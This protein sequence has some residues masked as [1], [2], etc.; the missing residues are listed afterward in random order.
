MLKQLESGRKAVLVSRLPRAAP[1]A[2]VAR[3]DRSPLSARCPMCRVADHVRQL[4]CVREIAV[5]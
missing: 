5:A 4:T 3:S 2:L 1:K